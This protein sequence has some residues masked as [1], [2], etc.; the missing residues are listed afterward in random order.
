METHNSPAKESDRANEAADRA[1]LLQASACA[2]TSLR[3]LLQGRLH[4]RHE[5]IGATVRLPNGQEFVVFRES[6]CDGEPGT[7]PVTLAVWFHLLGVPRG[8]RL[9][10]YLFERA[11][12]VNTILFAG[13]TGYRV[14]LWMVDPQTVDYAGLYSWR[15]AEEAEQYARYIVR[16]LSPL[17]RSGTVGYEVLRGT[18]F[19]EYLA[20]HGPTMPSVGVR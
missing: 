14:K 3:L 8:S 4:L 19:D 11:C 1:V 20:G 5:R 6:S 12:L 13:F 2:W 18:P 15:S 17:S 9:R 16:I 10:R 7:T